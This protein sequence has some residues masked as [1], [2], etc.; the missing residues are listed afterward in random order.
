MYIRRSVLVFLVLQLISCVTLK[1]LLDPSRSYK[2]TGEVCL[3][4]KAL[5]VLAI[6][7][8]KNQVSGTKLLHIEALL[9]RSLILLP[10]F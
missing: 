10:K 6:C 2:M 5:P 8:S 7:D 1:I 3:F 9:H 4:L